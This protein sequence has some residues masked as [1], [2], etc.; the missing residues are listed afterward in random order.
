MIPFPAAG[1]AGTRIHFQSGIE[2]RNMPRFAMT[3][4]IHENRML[5]GFQKMAL[6]QKAREFVL[7]GW[8]RSMELRFYPTR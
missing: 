6:G 5:S 8:N 3:G 4:R 2:P 7:P 1:K